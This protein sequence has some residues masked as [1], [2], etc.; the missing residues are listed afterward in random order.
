MINLGE[1]GHPIFRGTSALARGPL[2]SKG[3]GQLS[4]HYNGDSATRE[5]LFRIIIS[6]NQLSV[7]GAFSDW[8]EELAQLISDH[9]SSSTTRLVRSPESH[10]MLCQS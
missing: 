10:P 2:K 1:S 7:H 8:S 4:T 3:G 6:V 5:V 9:A